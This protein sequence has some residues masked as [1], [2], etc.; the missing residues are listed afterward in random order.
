MSAYTNLVTCYG[1]RS[2]YR[3]LNFFFLLVLCL[4]L[5]SCAST[6]L[7]P[8][9]PEVTVVGVKP[10][11][12]SGNEQRFLFTLNLNNPNSF[13]LPVEIIDVVAGFGGQ[14]VATGKSTAGVSV[15][16]DGNARV[17]IEITTHL[18][19]L[20]GKFLKSLGTG[21][22]DL[23]YRLDG[24]VKIENVPRSFK[25]ATSGNLLDATGDNN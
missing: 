12:L 3:C 14:E 16:A 11:S 17:D 23:T 6:P 10:I 2:E 4:G 1:N 18:K 7:S 15:P 20:F 19:D 9:R 5:S 8:Q 24:N 22:L 21:N 13:A 25:F